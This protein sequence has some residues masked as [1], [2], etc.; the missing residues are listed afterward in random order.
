MKID[1]RNI[2]PKH[3]LKKTFDMRTKKKKKERKNKHTDKI[4]FYKIFKSFV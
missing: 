3:L 4:N 1:V 2:H